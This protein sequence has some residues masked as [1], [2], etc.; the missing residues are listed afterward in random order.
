MKCQ[1]C[2]KSEVDF[3]YSANINGCVTEEHL[4]SECAASSGYDMGRMFSPENLFNGFFPIF[5][6]QSDYLP[7]VFPA[8]FGVP[9]RFA[10]PLIEANPCAAHSIGACTGQ[11]AEDQDVAVDDEMRARRELTMQMRKA[12]ENEDF[13]KAAELRDKLKG[14]EH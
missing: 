9:V 10:I 4:C 7:M 6:G 3:H 14:M 8:G 2:G 13:E 11:T 5:G 1:K 12:V